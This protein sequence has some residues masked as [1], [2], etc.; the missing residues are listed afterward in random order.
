M[1]TKTFTSTTSIDGG[2]DSTTGTGVYTIT[3]PNSSIEVTGATFNIDNLLPTGV[4][5]KLTWWSYGTKGES[6]VGFYFPQASAIG[7]SNAYVWFAYSYGAWAN[8]A[9]KTLTKTDSNSATFNTADYFNS[10]NSTMREYPIT[11]A[12]GRPSGTIY[13]QPYWTRGTDSD[14]MNECYNIGW[15]TIS[16][17]QKLVLNAPPTFTASSISYDTNYIYSGLT[18][19]SVTVSNATAQYGGDV[20]SIAFTIGNQTVTR[21]SNGTL[22]IALNAGGTFTPTVTVTD[23]RGQTTTQTFD[24][25][26]VNTY[27]AP[28]VSF[29]VTRTTSSGVE[30]DEGT[31]GF[32]E[33]TLTFSDVVATAVAPSVTLTSESGTQSTPTVTWYTT[34]ALTTTV[35]WANVASGD[36]VYG[37]F[38]G[39][40]PNYSY[41][42]TV[43]PRDS[44]GTGTAITQTISS[45]FYTID[46]LAGGH[47]IAFGQPASQTGFFCNMDATFEDA[48]TVNDDADFGADIFIELPDYQTAGTTDKA[49]YDAL[50]AL[51]WDSEVLS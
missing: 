26:T 12:I 1:A 28:S 21:S 19:A 13:S 17:D 4:T 25:I 23:S 20:T 15:S 42:V 22:S 18:T 6:G 16:L 39:L 44:E 37:L 7:S 50:V 36:T 49:I 43:R 33:A 3:Y 30:D 8:G 48:L 14:A 10:S 27:T 5:T 32:I 11:Y 24:P 46:F 45:A 35:T 47:G 2:G 31:Y 38:S 29:D 34:S 51:E 40:S 41:Q 9:T